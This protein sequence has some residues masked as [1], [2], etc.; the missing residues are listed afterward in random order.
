MFFY[1]WFSPNLFKFSRFF[2]T[3]ETL[4]LLCIKVTKQV[5]INP[6][7]TMLTL[8]LNSLSNNIFWSLYIN[9]RCLLDLDVK[10]ISLQSGHVTH[11]QYFRKPIFSCNQRFWASKPILYYCIMTFGNSFESCSSG[12]SV[13]KK[14]FLCL[15]TRPLGSLFKSFIF[16]SITYCSILV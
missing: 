12:L 15:M 4:L 13:Q 3:C 1:F 16:N 14:K 6:H 7:T 8:N 5:F 11:T 2:C 10:R 9:Y